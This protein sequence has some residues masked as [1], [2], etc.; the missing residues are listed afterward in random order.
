MSRNREDGYTIEPE[1]K[2]NHSQQ[3]SKTGEESHD[4]SARNIPTSSADKTKT[5]QEIDIASYNKGAKYGYKL[6]KKEEKLEEAKSNV[7]WCKEITSQVEHAEKRATL[8]QRKK[9]IEEFKFFLEDIKQ[10]R[11]AQIVMDK[12]NQAIGL[13][14]QE[15]K[16]GNI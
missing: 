15:I 3:P 7:L 9:M 10:F 4:C 1:I 11:M 8:S 14:E 6:A 12:I 2:T 13:Y 16:N 5:I